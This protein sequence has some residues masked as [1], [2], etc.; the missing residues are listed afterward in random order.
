MIRHIDL[1]GG[2]KAWYQYD[3]G[4]QRTRKHMTRQPQPGGTD[5]T[6]KEERIYL[7]GY[8]LYRCYINDPDDPIEE[9]ES[10]H[11][12]EGEQRVLL[13]DDVLV[14]KAS[15]QPGPSGSRISA[16]TLFRYQYG[17]HLGSV[18]LEL[19]DTA[20]RISYEEFH[21]YGT[22]AYRVMNSAIEAPV[23]RYRYTGMERDEE[24]G[25]AIHS[26][27]YFAS[28]IG[29]WA[30][31]DP[32]LLKGGINFYAYSGGNPICRLDHN[33]LDWIDIGD[34]LELQI[35][36][37]DVHDAHPYLENIFPESI[38]AGPV[39][40]YGT[41]RTQ[42]KTGQNA[43]RV[44]NNLKGTGG[45]VQAGHTYQ[46]EASVATQLPRA[47]R[48]NP[49]TMMALYSLRSPTRNVSTT[50]NAGIPAP[51]LPGQKFELPA[52][53]NIPWA[54]TNTPHRAQELLISNAEERSSVPRI[55]PITQDQARSAQGQ[56]K[57]EVLYRT[58]NTQWDERIRNSVLQSTRTTDQQRI[59][60]NTAVSAF[61]T[62]LWLN[63]SVTVSDRLQGVGQQ[64]PFVQELQMALHG[65][66]GLSATLGL[67]WLTG[68]LARAVQGVPVVAAAGAGGAVAGHA[69]RAS[70]KAVGMSNNAAEVMGFATAVGTGAY[71][72]TFVGGPVG[73]IVGAGLGALVGGG[74]Y[75]LAR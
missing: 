64:L 62:G 23:K 68:N 35:L 10:H 48:D 5:R 34:D 14:A 30:S 32:A 1:G 41:A 51:T 39:V 56:A 65:A 7:G 2:G 24:S 72:G 42:S 22:S 47:V 43:F 58:A 37:R 17:N 38:P 36:A 15:A 69:V 8:E 11:L 31:A 66:A 75:L 33:G 25:L 29:S 13:V 44:T 61:R 70:A 50:T 55:G 19:N 27:R 67:A 54:S 52:I 21:P 28:N 3:S 9:I 6:V 59:D 12:F 71:L 4:K 18:G 74:L 49:Q 20:R 45:A 46:V 40:S 26:A 16:Q 57:T 60:S 53:A 73:T 63:P